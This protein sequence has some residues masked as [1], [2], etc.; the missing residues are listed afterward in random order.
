MLYDLVGTGNIRED[1]EKLSHSLDEFYSVESLEFEVKTGQGK[2][3]RTTKEHKDLVFLKDPK[4]FFDHII[5]ERGLDREKVLIRVG[6]DGGQ[7]SFKVIVSIFETDYDPDITFST[8]EGPGN[9]L[10][11]SS[12]M[13]VMALCD[14]LQVKYIFRLSQGISKYGFI[15]G[16]L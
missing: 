10:T 14:D 1:L 15:V 12:R 16:D 9:R 8:K 11:G 7:G 13:L 5:A 3:A 4:E 6:L 2:N